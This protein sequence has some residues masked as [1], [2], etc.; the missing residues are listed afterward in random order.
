MLAA[1]PVWVQ[2]L[3][4]AGLVAGGVVLA[5]WCAAV[6]RRGAW[7]APV[8]GPPLSAARP[9]HAI[10]VFAQY[11]LFQSL[12]VGSVT[13][14]YAGEAVDRVG[15]EAWH[16]ALLTADAAKLFVIACAAIALYG[17]AHR[18]TEGPPRPPVTAALRDAAGGVLA[19]LLVTTAQAQAARVLFEWSGNP[20]PEHPV[21]LALQGGGL[22]P[23]IV[24]QLVVGAA[25][26]AP[27]CEEVLFRGIVQDAVQNATGRF[28]PAA[29]ASAVLFGLVHLPQPHAV[30]PL[31]T[32]G[33]VLSLVRL[34]TGRLWPAI[35]LHALFNGRTIALVLAGATNV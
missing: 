10:V 33:L 30:V 29:I 34:H 11:F 26:V 25:V 16:V 24:I 23:A 19:A 18:S 27:V 15:S 3:D 21:I 1:A 20:I 5:L 22:S 14:A 7:R 12:A 9:L 4:G 17:L 31:M 28:W 8:S 35:L 6:K 13:W 32:L 2:A